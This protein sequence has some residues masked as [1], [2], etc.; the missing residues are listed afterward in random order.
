M[1]KLLKLWKNSDSDW[2]KFSAPQLLM[3]VCLP[4]D[5]VILDYM[6]KKHSYQ[7]ISPDSFM[8]IDSIEK[9]LNFMKDF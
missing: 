6:K 7:I 2:R 8:N 5:Q 3:K 4:N 9:I 1:R